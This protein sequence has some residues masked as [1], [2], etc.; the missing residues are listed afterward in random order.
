MEV[1]LVDGWVRYWHEGV[2]LPLPAGLQRDLDETRR[3][4]DA[5]RQ[6]RL[7]AEQ[8]VARLRSE[9]DKLRSR[10]NGTRPE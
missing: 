4:L 7:A 9:V 1:A 5:E 3:Q 2:L 10:R 6:G 8:E